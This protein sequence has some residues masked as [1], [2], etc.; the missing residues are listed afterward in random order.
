MEKL[1]LRDWRYPS[2]LSVL[3]PDEIQ[4]LKITWPHYDNEALVDLLTGLPNR[5]A[6]EKALS[7]AEKEASVQGAGFAL[8]LLDIDFF[9]NVNDVHGHVAGDRVLKQFAERMLR[10]LR[11]SDLAARYGGEEFAVLTTACRKAFDIGERIRDAVFREAFFTP[12]GKQLALSCSFGCALFPFDSFS[13]DE[14]LKKADHALYEAKRSG[15]NR[16]KR[17]GGGMNA[18]PDSDRTGSC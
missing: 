14:L 11:R 12:E 17:F 2:P 3:K 16:G 7:L 9:K 10:E 5:R 13:A 6:F 1:N 18:L 8:L 4:D 15:R